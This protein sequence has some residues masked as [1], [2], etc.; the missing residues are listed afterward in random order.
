MRICRSTGRF[1]TVTFYRS[2]LSRRSD[3]D[4]GRDR[5]WVTD[6]FLIS[7]LPSERISSISR[8]NSKQCFFCLTMRREMKCGKTPLRC[9]AVN[10]MQYSIKEA[11]VTRA[12]MTKTAVASEGVQYR[13]ARYYGTQGFSDILPGLWT[14]DRKPF[15]TYFPVKRMK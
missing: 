4:S 13:A 15:L 9:T 10:Q 14:F 7:S 6:C 5:E 8:G 2:G 3:S 11:R 1:S 12:W